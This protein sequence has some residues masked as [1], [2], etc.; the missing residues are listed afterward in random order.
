MGKAFTSDGKRN[1]RIEI[2]TF[3]GHGRGARLTT[4]FDGDGRSEVFC[5]AEIEGPD[6]YTVLSIA[7]VQ[8]MLPTLPKDGTIVLGMNGP[9]RPVIFH[10]SEFAH[11]D[12]FY[13]VMPLLK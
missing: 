10:H 7:Y 1:V 8:E 3:S 6:D 9:T 12:Y 2:G 5:P 11:D 13:L 4:D